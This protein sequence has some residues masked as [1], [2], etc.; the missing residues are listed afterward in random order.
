MMTPEERA[1]QPFD[2]SPEIDYS[3]WDAQSRC[4]AAIRADR[5]EQREAEWIPVSP[6]T[7]PEIGEWLWVIIG[8][9]VQKMPCVFAGNRWDWINEA[10]S[11]P[12]EVVTHYQLV[13]RPAPPKASA[14]RAM[15][16]EK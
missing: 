10:D 3:S 9:V 7:M 12:M 2:H 14:V 11:A 8:G 6:E 16:E 13:K 15:G 4:A 1:A 5:E